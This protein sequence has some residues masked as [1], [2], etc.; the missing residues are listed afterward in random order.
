MRT[1]LHDIQRYQRTTD[2]YKIIKKQ[3]YFLLNIVVS[4]DGFHLHC[5]D[6]MMLKP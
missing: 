3:I 6:Q 4:F 2:Y 5:L 1:N